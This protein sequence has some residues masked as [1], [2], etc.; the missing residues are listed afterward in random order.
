MKLPGFLAIAMLYVSTAGFSNVPS[1]KQDCDKIDVKVEVVNTSNG[2]DNGHVKIELVKGSARNIRYIFCKKD[3]KVLNENQFGTS[4]LE[5]LAK[6]EYLC[7]VNNA[8]CSKKIDFT[9]K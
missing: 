8:D 4:S 1:S 9:I 6:G 5:G 2:Q 3:G 7:I